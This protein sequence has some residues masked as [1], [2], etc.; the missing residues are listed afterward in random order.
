MDRPRDSS[1]Y[2]PSSRDRGESA[3]TRGSEL[4][5]RELPGVF[6]RR[7]TLLLGVT[8]GVFLAVALLI[9]L[10][11]AQY[12]SEASVRVRVEEMSGMA[13]R[14]AGAGSSLEDAFPLAGALSLPEL[15]GADVTTEIGILGSRRILE[16]VA[17]SLALHVSLSRPRGEFRTEVLE[18]IRAGEDAPRGTYTL[19][20]QGDGTYRASSRGTR[21]E[22]S[23]P[24][25]V[26]IGEDFRVGPMT[27]RLNPELAED[28]PSVVRFSVTPFRRMMN[29]LRRDV[30]IERADA[31]SRLVAVRYRHN[32]PHLAQALVN[33]TV[34]RFMDYSLTEAT[35]DSRRE[36]RIL[37]EQVS[38]YAEDLRTVEDRLRAYQEQ[39]R[40]VAPEEQAIAQV[41]RIAELQVGHDLM[42]VERQALAELL[43][44][45]R[46]RAAGHDPGTPGDSAESPYRRLATFPS[47]ITNEAVQQLLN[48]LSALENERSQLLVRRTEQNVDVRRV[49]DRIREV[50]GQLHALAGNYLES[51]NVQLASSRA[52]LDRFQAELEQMPGVELEYT[53][54]L[55]D[56]RLL[57]EIYLVLQARLTEATIQ[58]AIDDARVRVVDLGVVEDRPAFPRPEIILVLGALLGLMMGTFSVVAAET[59]SP[60]V[61]SRSDA[62]EAAGTPVLGA[63]PL[64]SAGG[65]RG[66]KK[67]LGGLIA[68]TDPWDPG[69]EG[70]RALALSLLTR[71]PA[72][73]VV[74]VAGAEGGE[75]RT[76]VAA[77]LGVAFAHQGLRAAVVDG[78]LRGGDLHELFHEPREPGW[79]SAV[80]SGRALEEVVR[81]VDLGSAPG[82]LDL[83]PAG[84][85]PSHPSEV[86]GS[87]KVVGFLDDLRGRYDVVVVD[88]PALEQGHDGAVLAGLADGAL[89]V[90]REGRT[91]RERLSEAAEAV[92][93]SRGTVLGVVLNGRSVP[94]S[95]KLSSGRG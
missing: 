32:D 68:R 18:V 49:Q 13:G 40:L 38:R 78:D 8:G 24:D 41:E 42:E 9:F 65:G 85:L 34:S 61:R 3:R 25:R 60:Y 93:R 76:T 19:R 84:T 79:T 4:N 55:R 63:L 29:R 69:S 82:A 91:R 43:R 89:L 17:D 2:D 30:R 52:S 39:E 83:L 26:S 71:D 88:T 23:L 80:V 50:E 95:G 72:P 94:W 36:A 12:E 66:R 1:G 27:F 67:A 28:P 31:G 92:R 46:G 57:T 7:W 11:P 10:I 47:F 37:E 59:T 73:K 53:R 81:E 56:R 87:G 74:A 48:T 33:G 14:L 20:R 77:N 35:G 22:V 86:L 62:H 58:E 5:L 54:L 64:F 21:D 16:A 75:G 90:A 44:E 45:V 15:G 6:R 70:F 51:L